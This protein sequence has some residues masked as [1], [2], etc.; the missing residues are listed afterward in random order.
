MWNI[1][2]SPIN[3]I[4]FLKKSNTFNYMIIHDFKKFYT[5]TI[6]IKSII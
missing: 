2:L 1:F 6:K 3:Y 4:L 5:S